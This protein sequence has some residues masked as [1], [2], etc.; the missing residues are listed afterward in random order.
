VMII[1][2]VIEAFSTLVMMILFPTVVNDESGLSEITV[3]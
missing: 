1:F 2:L 3:D